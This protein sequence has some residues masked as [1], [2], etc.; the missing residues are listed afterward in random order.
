MIV[1]RLPSLL[2]FHRSGSMPCPYIEGLFEQQVF[3]ELSGPT[4]VNDYN[5]LSRAGFRRSHHIVYRPSCTEC[6]ACVPIRIAIQ[7]FKYGKTWKRILKRN[8]HIK[9]QDVGLTATDE[10][11][12]LFS[13]YVQTRHWDGEMATMN[14]QDYQNLI[15]ASPI[16]TTIFEFRDENE[17][18]IAACL[19]DKLDDG[20]SAV[21]SYFDPILE[22]D[23]LGSY[24]ILK[25][26]EEALNKG[27]SYV[28]LG[29]WID[30]SPK[31]AYKAR[32]Q[33][34]E[35]FMENGWKSVDTNR[36]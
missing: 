17:K 19:T 12:L 16:N 11:F 30:N 9:M 31:M 25:L 35:F 15:T 13:N 26:I 4:A 29:F 34:L 33:P 10:Q 36:K 8:Q 21:Y 20:L 32:F 14:K 23:S 1:Q 28:Y 27:F 3:V 2:H 22:T 6:T 18:L 5:K 7:N 24:M